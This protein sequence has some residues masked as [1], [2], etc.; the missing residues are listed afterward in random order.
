MKFARYLNTIQAFFGLKVFVRNYNVSI[1]MMNVNSCEFDK[2]KFGKAASGHLPLAQ[3]IWSQ[4]IQSGDIVIDATCGNGL[5]SLN[6]A[7]LCINPGTAGKL[8]CID[9]QPL[10]INA[11]KSRLSENLVNFDSYSNHIEFCCQSHE[12][13]PEEILPNSVTLI[14]YNLGYLPR[15][16]RENFIVGQGTITSAP[17]TLMSLNGAL[18]LLKT[19]GVITVTSYRG[20][21]G[22]NEEYL[23]VDKF[24]RNLDPKI[25]RVYSHEPLN[26]PLSPVL[27]SIFK[28]TAERRL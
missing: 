13:F 18:S 11:T 12:Y 26:R 3:T 28:S 17:T 23:E 6:L 16:N 21:P 5:D 27:F 1:R 10:A 20:H 4:I 9:I 2:F 7:K 8:F 22:G 25:W 24:C 15:G 14:N 19:G